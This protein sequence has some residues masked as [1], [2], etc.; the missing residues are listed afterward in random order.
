MVAIMNHVV[1]II[2]TDQTLY[3]NPNK[4]KTQH[5]NLKLLH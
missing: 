2:V 3:D 5:Q 4:I 1:V